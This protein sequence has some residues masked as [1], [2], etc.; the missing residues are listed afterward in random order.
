[1]IGG[2]QYMSTDAISGKQEGKERITQALFGL[3][4]AIASW[5]ILAT[6]SP[7]LLKVNLTVISPPQR[8]FPISNNMT[9]EAFASIACIQEEIRYRSYLNDNQCRI[10]NSTACR[11]ITTPSR[12]YCFDITYDNCSSS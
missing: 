1:M 3:G 8:C 11:V 10:L 9:G 5:L 12:Q 7:T 4:L 2:L 6:I